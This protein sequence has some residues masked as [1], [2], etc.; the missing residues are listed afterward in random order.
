MNLA[1]AW[2]MIQGLGDIWND[3][4]TTIGEKFTQTLITLGMIL[5]MVASGFSSLKNAKLKDML[6][7][8]GSTVQTTLENIAE[9]KITL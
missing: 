7:T 4:D 6:V 5:P 1:M 8:I 2:Q 3:E 9:K